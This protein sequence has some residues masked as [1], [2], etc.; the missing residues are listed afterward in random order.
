M[1]TIPRDLARKYAFDWEDEPLLFVR[2]GETFEVETYDASTG[3]FKSVEDKAVPARRPGFDRFPPQANPIA[4]PIC[5]EGAERG[6]VLVVAQG[7]W[8]P[9]RTELFRS[10][11]P[12]FAG[13]TAARAV[14]PI[15]A[16]EEGS[17]RR[18]VSLW[19][20]PR[21]H[22]VH[23]PVRGGREVAVVV[24]A[25]AQWQ[26]REWDAQA[27]GDAVVQSLATSHAAIADA[28]AMAA[29]HAP[30]RRWALHR[31]PPLDDWVNGRV[32]L[33]GDAVDGK[34]GRRN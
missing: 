4:G 3:Y 11:P 30:W 17:W 13:K 19:L 24:I 25:R 21:T 28:L 1:Q 8:S 29:R 23:Y 2:P 9:L 31:M 14:I 33:L 22:V 34:H 18:A 12:R 5:L 26:G 32:A 20:G 7:L 16:V 6:D 10:A 27:D 15:D